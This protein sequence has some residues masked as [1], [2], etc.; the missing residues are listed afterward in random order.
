[1]LDILDECLTAPCKN[2]GTCK[3]L[4][5]SFECNCTEQFSGPQCEVGKY[6]FIAIFQNWCIVLVH[7][8]SRG[9]KFSNIHLVATVS[10]RDNSFL[11]YFNETKAISI[12][13]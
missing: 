4:L 6:F 1:M 12:V 3:D 9:G 11:V 7:G 10:P 8:I 13:L 5:G 2:G